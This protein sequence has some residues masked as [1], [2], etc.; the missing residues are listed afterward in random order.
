MVKEEL[1]IRVRSGS[2]ETCL[3]IFLTIGEDRFDGVADIC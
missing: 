1:L 2:R 3:F